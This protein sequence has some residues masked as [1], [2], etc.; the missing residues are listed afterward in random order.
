VAKPVGGLARIDMKVDEE[1]LTSPNL[2]R[3]ILQADPPRA[4]GYD[5]LNQECELIRDFFSAAPAA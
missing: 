1:N 4:D 2:G 3:E 5:F